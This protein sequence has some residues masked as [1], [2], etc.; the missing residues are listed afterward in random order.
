MSNSNCYLK[1][2]FLNEEA[3]YK[4]KHKINE[5]IFKH[6]NLSF[7]HITC[8]MKTTSFTICVTLNLFPFFHLKNFHL[9][10]LCSASLFLFRYIVVWE[11]GKKSF[12]TLM[13]NKLGCK[14]GKRKVFSFAFRIF[15]VYLSHV[16]F[17]CIF[18]N[19]FLL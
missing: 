3:D 5:K 14:Q 1:L 19:T 15:P 18:L 6:E 7:R 9:S 8:M 10:V 12:L 4:V 2:T 17:L 16:F 13:E 11:E